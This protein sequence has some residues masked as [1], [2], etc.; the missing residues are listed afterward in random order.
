MAFKISYRNPA[1]SIE[2]SDRERYYEQINFELE[3]LREAFPGLSVKKSMIPAPSSTMGAELGVDWIIANYPQILEFAKHIAQT[4]TAVSVISTLFFQKKPKANAAPETKS[5][6]EG[7]TSVSYEEFSLQL[8]ATKDE[9]ERFSSEVA[10]RITKQ[11][12][13]KK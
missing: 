11:Q 8:P 12:G 1:G 5:L 13:T 4:L 7:H 2:A 9:I 10:E 3:S 6:L